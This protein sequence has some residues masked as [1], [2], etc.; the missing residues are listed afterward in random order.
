MSTCGERCSAPLSLGERPADR[1]PP[2]HAERRARSYSPHDQRPTAPQ[3]RP[4]P[5]IVADRGWP[6]APA[7][8][9]DHECRVDTGR[10]D[11]IVLRVRV[12]KSMRLQNTES[13]I[14]LG[15]PVRP[16]R[17]GWRALSAG[18]R[19]L[20]CRD[21]RSVGAARHSSKRTRHRRAAVSPRVG[22][23][24]HCVRATKLCSS[25]HL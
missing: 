13:V 3:P 24:R 10:H 8:P 18:P 6:C 14:R 19:P 5:R 9:P 25:Q 21:R 17:S 22:D 7:A 15:L 4:R 2:H 11:P 23:E 1:G 16:A 20:L 12:P